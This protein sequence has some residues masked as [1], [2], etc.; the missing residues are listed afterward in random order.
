MS[1]ADPRLQ[2]AIER[3][4]ERGSLGAENEVDLLITAEEVGSVAAYLIADLVSLWDGAEFKGRWLLWSQSSEFYEREP[5]NS[6]Y[7]FDSDHPRVS[8]DLGEFS[9]THLNLY[10]APRLLA[11][12]KFESCGVRPSFLGQVTS[13]EGK[14]LGEFVLDIEPDQDPEI[15][16]RTSRAFFLMA[17][18]CLAVS[19]SEIFREPAWEKPPGETIDEVVVNAAFAIANRHYP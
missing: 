4:R 17:V 2:S 12:V 13:Y 18:P 1:D 6:F 15:Q 8:L 7:E 19:K 5:G 10:V 11:G 9:R 16:R 3:L 14:V